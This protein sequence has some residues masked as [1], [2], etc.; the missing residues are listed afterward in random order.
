MLQA[1]SPEQDPGQHQ[2]YRSGAYKG[3]QGERVRWREEFRKNELCFAIKLMTCIAPVG[4]FSSMLAYLIVLAIE[5][6]Q[7]YHYFSKKPDT[8]F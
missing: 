7:T 3:G 2:D 6:Y 5:I 1:T 8:K 4:L